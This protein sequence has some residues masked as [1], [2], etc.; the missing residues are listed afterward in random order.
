VPIPEGEHTVELRYESW[1][2]QVGV[3]ISLIACVVLIALAAA[4]GVRWWRKSADGTKT[5]LGGP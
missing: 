5:T 4:V 3:V 2:L 1:T